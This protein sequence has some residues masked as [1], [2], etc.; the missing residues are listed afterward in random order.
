MDLILD[1]HKTK[2]AYLLE[3]SD[4]LAWFEQNPDQTERVRPAYRWEISR[5]E[6]Y[7]KNVVGVVV[8][9]A[10]PKGLLKKFFGP[11]HPLA[12]ELAESA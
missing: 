2:L 10:Q 8:T 5:Y 7:G 12:E 6:E 4:D 1:N 11:D 9:K 3:N